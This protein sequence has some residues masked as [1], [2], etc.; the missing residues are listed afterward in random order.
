MRP[1]PRQIL[2]LA[3]LAALVAPTLA[4][5]SSSSSSSG[6]RLGLFAPNTRLIGKE[7]LD[8]IKPGETTAD[9]VDAVLGPPTTIERLV[10]PGQ[11]IWKYRYQ[12]VGNRSYRLHAKNDNSGTVRTIYIQ[13]ADNTVTDT[14]ID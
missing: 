8:R 10:D 6:R 13:L 9:W 11:E 3:L 4:A 12:L 7:T 5:C 2:T 14:W 1:S